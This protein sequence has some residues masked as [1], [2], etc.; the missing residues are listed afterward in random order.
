M[1][2]KTVMG[3]FIFSSGWSGAGNDPLESRSLARDRDSGRCNNRERRGA[4][5]NPTLNA[6]V[7]NRYRK[8][9]RD[10][11][12]LTALLYLREALLEERYEDCGEFI[13]IA[14]EFGASDK[15]V[16]NLLEDP[17]RH[18]KS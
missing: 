5:M 16:R 11:V 4:N 3:F 17:R 7:S 1:I 15:E 13:A 2:G 18:P 12:R 14:L 10:P 8:R 9:A 6:A